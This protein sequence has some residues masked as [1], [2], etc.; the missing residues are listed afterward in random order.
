MENFESYCIGKKID[1]GKFKSAEPDLYA[2]FAEEFE[3]MHPNSF[4]EQK[5]FYINNLRRKYLLVAPP[6]AEAETPVK[7]MAGPVI[8]RPEI[9]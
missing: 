2:R 5:K 1:A 3:T 6:V 9:K 8:K 7:R 4:T